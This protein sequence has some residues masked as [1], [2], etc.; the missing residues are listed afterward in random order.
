MY[1]SQKNFPPHLS[2]FTHIQHTHANCRTNAPR[3]F[4][5]VYM[6]LWKFLRH[7]YCLLSVTTHLSILLVPLP[8][9][10]SIPWLLD[11]V[12]VTF[13]IVCTNLKCWQHAKKRSLDLP[14]ISMKL[15]VKLFPPF[16]SPSPSPNCSPHKGERELSRTL[17]FFKYYKNVL[18]YNTYKMHNNYSKHFC[19]TLFPVVLQPSFVLQLSFT[20][21]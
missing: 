18:I 14:F 3:T 1:R 11:F 17:Y 5:G 16:S 9:F 19:N 2:P 15:H 8:M 21:Y 7:F 20:Y 6:L 10:N 12:Q 13:T 4:S